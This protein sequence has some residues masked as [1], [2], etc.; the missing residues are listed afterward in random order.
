MDNSKLYPLKFAPILKHKI[1]G[2]DKIK[3]IYR[4]NSPEMK[5]VGESWDVSALGDDDSEVINGFLEGNSLTDLVEVYMGDLVGDRV[6]SK[7]GLDFPILLKILDANDRISIQVHPGEEVNDGIV[8]SGKNEMWYILD[9]GPDAYV[10]AGFNRYVSKSEFVDHINNNTLD[11]VLN[12]I[13]VK[14]GDMIYV[15]SGCVHS[16]GGGCLICEIQQSSDVVYRVYDYNRSD[17]NGNKR[18]LHIEKA[19]QTVDYEHWQNKKID[20]E[21]KQNDIV[22]V[23]DNEFFTVNC[24]EIDKTKEYEVGIIDSFILLTC[25]EGHVTCKFSDDYLT[26]VD[27]ETLLIPAEMTDLLLV[28]TVPSKLLETYIKIGK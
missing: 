28:P 18:P 8:T 10:I 21:L 2:G 11:E 17:D 12:K 19:V 13:P 6:Y 16:M 20:V 1:W 22:N 14:K 25:V 9:A 23:I 5:K 26:L 7:F 15:P 4:H 24:I 3:N 27:G